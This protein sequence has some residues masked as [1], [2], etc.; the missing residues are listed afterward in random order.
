MEVLATPEAKANKIFIFKQLHLLDNIP[1]S[2]IS[3]LSNGQCVTGFEYLAYEAL[4]LLLVRLLPSVG[5]HS[6]MGGTGI[7]LQSLHKS[8]LG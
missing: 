7:G 4:F 5:I 1:M 8:A 6:R 3:F 2:V